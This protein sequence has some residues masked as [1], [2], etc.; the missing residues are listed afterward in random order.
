GC[1][2]R[3]RQ[4]NRP[5]PCST[6]F[7]CLVLLDHVADACCHPFRTLL[8][9]P[10]SILRLRPG[11][12]TRLTG[13]GQFPGLEGRGGRQARHLEDLL[14]VERLPRDQGLSERIE[15]RAVCLQQP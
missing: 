2:L 15:L 7:P 1:S 9:L 6:S 14:L 13:S 4:P 3:P 10:D 8:V 11:A 12:L 5:V